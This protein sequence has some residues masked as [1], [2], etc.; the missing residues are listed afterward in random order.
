MGQF[1]RG[2]E[3]FLRAKGACKKK[4]LDWFD[5]NV[6]VS[7]IKCYPHS[8]STRALKFSQFID[9]FV[10]SKFTKEKHDISH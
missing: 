4:K 10:V 8:F 6:I 7:C 3:N 1:P 9:V 2:V 5:Q